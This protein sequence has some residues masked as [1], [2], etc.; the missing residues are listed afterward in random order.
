MCATAYNCRH[1]LFVRL[2]VKVV[3]FAGDTAMSPR[4]L[5][6]TPNTS[7]ARVRSPPPEARKRAQTKSTPGSISTP[8][9]GG[10]T[11][12]ERR[13]TT[14]NFCVALTENRFR[15][16]DTIDTKHLHNNVLTHDT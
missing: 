16:N 2:V 1:T 9:K 15:E 8:R 5:Q 4:S 10:I 3:D 11:P 13:E 7:P 6:T 14:P 12:S